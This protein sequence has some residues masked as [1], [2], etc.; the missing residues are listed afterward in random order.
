MTWTLVTPDI[1][2]T[3]VAT[4]AEKNTGPTIQ[5]YQN[6]CQYS[7]EFLT[8]AMVLYWR[9]TQK[10]FEFTYIEAAEQ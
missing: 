6:I 4:P 9:S 7:K 8:F 3:C 1:H 5:K 10:G 2:S